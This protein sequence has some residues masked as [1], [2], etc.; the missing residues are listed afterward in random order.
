[1]PQFDPST[2]ATQIF[3]LVVTFVGLYLI[4]YKVVLPKISD[5]LETRQDKIE[6][7]ID[8]AARLKSEAEEVLAAYHKALDEARSEAQAQ[9]KA[10][11]DEMAAAAAK[12]HEAFGAELA[13]RTGVA[14]G[15][16]AKAKDDAVASIKE[17]AAGA[18]AAAV[19]RLA[20]VEASDADAQAA[21]AD[22]LEGSG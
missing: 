13:K 3:W 22:V 6:D 16:I 15:R 14:E 10:T 18:A 21:V 9:V 20:G 11:A 17:V 19:G 7:D 12:R 4:L 1:M 8:R 2:F 5:V